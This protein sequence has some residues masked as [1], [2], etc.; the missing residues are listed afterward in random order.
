MK[1]GTEIYLAW[2]FFAGK[3]VAGGLS[4]PLLGRSAAPLAGVMSM[5]FCCA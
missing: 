5:V 2:E 1:I 3:G 4:S